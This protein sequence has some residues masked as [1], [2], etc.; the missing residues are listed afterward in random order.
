MKENVSVTGSLTLQDCTLLCQQD[1]MVDRGM[2]RAQQHGE[3]DFVQE[4]VMEA[5]K[6][7]AGINGIQDVRPKHHICEPDNVKVSAI[8][9]S[10]K[11]PDFD[12]LEDLGMEMQEVWFLLLVSTPFAPP[13]KYGYPAYPDG[14]PATAI[15][16]CLSRRTVDQMRFLRIGMAEG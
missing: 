3:Q 2:L 16:T 13:P 7:E 9:N 8:M 11:D 14:R 1:F 10:Y 15:S 12:T 4:Q 5:F 6:L